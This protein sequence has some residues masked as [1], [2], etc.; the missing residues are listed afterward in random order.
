MS[1]ILVWKSDADGKLFEDKTKYQ[2]H[3]RK[4]AAVRNSERKAAKAAADFDAFLT[5]M[6]NTVT[7]IVELEKFITENFN[8]FFYNGMKHALWKCDR[9]PTIA[10]KMAKIKIDVQWNDHVSNSHSCP[11]NGVQN[12]DTR[13][14]YNKGKPTGYPGW[15]G[16]IEFVVEAGM[17]NHKKNP[18]K[19]DS[20]G[21]DYFKDT[22]INTGTGG[23]NG[24]SYGYDV[25]L[26]AADFPA[27]TLAHEKAIT[28]NIL[29]DG[30]EL[31]FA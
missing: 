31:E 11:R 4:L 10:H 2:L 20:Y 6:G 26:F 5:K 19:L 12:F 15:K 25:K 16:R 23:G 14:E 24:Q 9:K 18:Y 22:G 8:Q 7:S 1:Q 17:S 21:G 27:M 3:L 30:N 13:A 28:W 29:V